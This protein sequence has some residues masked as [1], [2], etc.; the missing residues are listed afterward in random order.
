[1]TVRASSS[2]TIE[3]PGPVGVLEGIVETPAVQSPVG[4]ALF[5]HP[6]PL[7]HGTMHNKV[8]HTLARSILELGGIAVRFNFRGV[9]E[10]AGSF[11]AGEGEQDDAV[12]V[13]EWMRERWPGL[14]LYLGGFSF[15]AMV[16]LRAVSRIL[17]AGLI[18]VALPVE[19]TT[20]TIEQP[21]C[22]WLIVQGGSDE[23]VDTDAVIEWLN[24]LDPGP[25]IRV[26]E[27]ADHFFH[28]RLVELRRS[29]V[30]FLRATCP[31]R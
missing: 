15:G 28:G 23:I 17:P 1:M 22:L 2:H 25:E 27:G 29:V 7:Y 19:R 21:R 13:A 18:T 3:V 16:S 5:C 14:P 6:H 9:G 11:D 30:E 12:S 10:S 4:M 24:M 20:S 26:M 31:T 8:V